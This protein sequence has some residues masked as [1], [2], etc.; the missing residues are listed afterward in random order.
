MN[1]KTFIIGCGRLG[2]SIAADAYAKGDNVT[3]IDADGEAFDRL[4]DAFAGFTVVADATD[5]KSLDDLGIADVDDLIITTGNDNDNLF[6]AHLADRVYHI[7]HI[8]VRFNDPG[9][10]LLLSGYNVKP[11]YPFQLSFESFVSLKK[12]NDQ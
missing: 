5:A 3:V 11:I 4:N 10:G 12:E 2:S 1:N 6:I 8:Y 9:E 7:P